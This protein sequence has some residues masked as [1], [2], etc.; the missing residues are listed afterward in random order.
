MKFPSIIRLPRNK[1]FD[2]SPRYFD[3]VK[4]EIEERTERIK[5]ELAIEQKQGT[6]ST[7]SRRNTLKF[8]RKEHAKTSASLLQLVI[9]AT[10]S[11]LVFGWLYFGN[12]VFYVLFLIFPIYVFFRLRSKFK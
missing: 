5:R 4:D 9:A 7:G 8:E 3:P 1:S 10:L 12:D 6:N 11:L 2:F